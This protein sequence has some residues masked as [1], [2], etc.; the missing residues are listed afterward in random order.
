MGI[1]RILMGVGML[2]VVGVGWDANSELAV[3]FLD[4]GQGDA[5][6]LEDGGQQVLVDGGEGRVVL[7]RLVEEMPW[8]DRRI[9]VLVVSHPQRDHLEGLLYVLERYEV[10]LVILPELV[11]DSQLQATWLEMIS[12]RKIPVQMARVGQRLKVDRWQMLVL[13]PLPG[14]AAEAAARADINNGSVMM[15]ADGCPGGEARCLSVLLTG[16]AEAP[17]EQMLVRAVRQEVLNV[18]VLK[19]GHHGSKTSTTQALVTAADPELV[20][21]SVGADNTFGHPHPSV[22]QRLS[23]LSV[24]RTDEA[25][26]VRLWWAEDSWRVETSM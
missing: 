15:R 7:E 8:F 22:L 1:R 26:S 13:G 4:V 2:V 25:G 3:T 24:L 12:E 6:L 11:H 19:A 17:V 5:I 10:G 16:D 20:V 18:D 9:E 21:I 23:S 14:E